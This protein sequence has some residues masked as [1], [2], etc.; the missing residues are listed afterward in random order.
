MSWARALLGLTPIRKTSLGLEGR[1]SNQRSIQICSKERFS[2]FTRGGVKEKSQIEGGTDEV[3]FWSQ[4]AWL[5]LSSRVRRRAKNS[6][7]MSRNFRTSSRSRERLVGGSRRSSRLGQQA[8]REPSK[9]ER[10]AAAES[11]RVGEGGDAVS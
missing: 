5:L 1:S 10:W 7:Y 8:L 3:L 6:S 4:L 9:L 2:G 11:H